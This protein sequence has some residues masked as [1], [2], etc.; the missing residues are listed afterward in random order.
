MELN[1]NKVERDILE[2]AY[3]LG[4]IGY[5]DGSHS[6]ASQSLLRSMIKRTMM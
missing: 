6:P 5:F 1:V 3:T 4:R 2:A